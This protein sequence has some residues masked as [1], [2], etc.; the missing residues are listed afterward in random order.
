MFLLSG[1]IYLTMHA[2]LLFSFLIFYIHALEGR[3]FYVSDSC[4]ITRKTGYYF[5][6]VSCV[7]VFTHTHPTSLHTFWQFIHTYTMLW[8]SSN[9]ALPC[10]LHMLTAFFFPTSPFLLHLFSHGAGL[11]FGLPSLIMVSCMSMDRAGPM[12]TLL[13]KMTPAGADARQSLALVKWPHCLR[14]RGK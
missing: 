10:L 3:D 12:P 11:G 2:F 6:K 5:P 14:G 8:A 4:K 1:H 7:Y 13:K 9:L